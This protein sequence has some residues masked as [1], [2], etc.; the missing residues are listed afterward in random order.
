MPMAFFPEFLSCRMTRDENIDLFAAILS[1]ITIELNSFSQ[2]I[3]EIFK[4]FQPLR[5][6]PVEFDM[7]V[8]SILWWSKQNFK[9]E[10]NL[11]EFQKRAE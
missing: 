10:K 7:I 5:Y 2:S 11:T 8:Q 9:F 6:L 1:R 4:C 3:P